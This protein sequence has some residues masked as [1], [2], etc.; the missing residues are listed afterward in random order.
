MRLLDSTKA[1]GKLDARSVA[2]DSLLRWMLVY[3]LFVALF[4]RWFLE[5]ILARGGAALGADLVP[6]FTLVSSY[7]LLATPPSFCG[8]LVGF[9][10]LDERDDGTL[11]AV[12]VTPVRPSHYLAYRLGVPIAVST[13]LTVIAFPLGGVTDFHPV[14]VAAAALGM[15]PIGPLTALA[16]AIVAANKVQGFA[17]MKASGLLGVAPIVAWFVDPPWQWLFGIV[18]F[19]WPAM[20][21]WSAMEGSADWTL[22]AVAAVYQMLLLVL[23]ARKFERATS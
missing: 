20:F 19:Y 10:L 13:A 11:A 21:L 8:A 4:V 5:P 15:A 23:L 2:R 6:Y 14:V 3:P 7:M 12:K 18:P 1:F 16:L 9:L 17:L 22:L